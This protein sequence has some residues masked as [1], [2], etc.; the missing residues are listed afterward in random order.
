[1]ANN[2]KKKVLLVDDDPMIV[3]M[4]SRKLEHGGYKVNLAFNGE[5]GVASA[6]KDKPDIILLDIMMPK[7]NGI[8]A[9]KKL[10][11]D[12]E[13]KDVPVLILTNLGDRPEDVEKA[14]KIGALEYLVK[15][16]IQL[17]D[18]MSVIKKYLK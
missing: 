2:G 7:M 18:L 11:A 8:E 13:L 10:K 15:A 6:K 12:A 9:L 1:M 4:Y 3:R 16:N 14:K 5:E 17:E